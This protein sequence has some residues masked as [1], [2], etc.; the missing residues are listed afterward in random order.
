MNDRDSKGCHIKLLLKAGNGVL[1]CSALNP[2]LRSDVS[3]Y[4]KKVHNFDDSGF[5]SVVPKKGLPIGKYQ[6]GI[7]ISFPGS[8]SPIAQFT[9]RYIE[10]R[11]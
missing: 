5:E 8:D 7:L 6:V 10:Q 2:V 11:F 1:Y 4:L 9:D 3:D